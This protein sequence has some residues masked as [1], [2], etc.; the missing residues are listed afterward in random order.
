[1]SW[2]QHVIFYCIHLKKVTIVWIFF[3]SLEIGPCWRSCMLGC[4]SRVLSLGQCDR[5]TERMLTD[6]IQPTQKKRELKPRDKDGWLFCTS[7]YSQKRENQM[8]NNE[9]LFWIKKNMSTTI[10]NFG[11]IIKENLTQ[12][13]TKLLAYKRCGV[14]PL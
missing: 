3:I 2:V 12:G 14:L 11:R 4:L 5:R 6:L 9:I 13:W 8:Y 1:M 10:R 7:V